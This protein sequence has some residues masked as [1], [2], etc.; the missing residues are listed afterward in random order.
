ME[1]SECSVH[2][3]RSRANSSDFRRPFHTQLR[4]QTQVQVHMVQAE[5]PREFHHLSFPLFYI[6]PSP[7][8]NHTPGPSASAHKSLF[9]HTQSKSDIYK[10][11]EK[12]KNNQKIKLNIISIYT[13]HNLHGLNP[14]NGYNCKLIKVLNIH[15]VQP[16]KVSFSSK[17]LT[18]DNVIKLSAH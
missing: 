6:H 17:T 10:I 3:V 12:K 13:H 5:F 4:R 16:G 15:T 7:L 14:T 8:I 2:N 1:N 18:V 11:H 9:K